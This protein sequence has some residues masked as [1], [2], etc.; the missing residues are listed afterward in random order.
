MNSW[1]SKS[2]SVPYYHAY[3]QELDLVVGLRQVQGAVQ[4]GQGDCVRQGGEV[5]ED[6]ATI[7]AAGVKFHLNVMLGHQQVLGVA[8]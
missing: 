6:S 7:V 2:W 8:G 3:Y 5:A 4:A 1:Q